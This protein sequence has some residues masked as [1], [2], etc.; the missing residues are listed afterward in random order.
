MKTTLIYII[1]FSI[2][3]LSCLQNRE[4]EST[5][6]YEENSGNNALKIKE[7]DSTIC[8]SSNRD[9][10]LYKR[11]ITKDSLIFKSKLGGRFYHGATKRNI[12]K[13]FKLDT[14]S[15]TV[16][17]KGDHLNIY[18][19]VYEPSIDSKEIFETIKS[20]SKTTDNLN[21]YHDFFKR[22]LIFTHFNS[23]NKITIIAFN[24]FL[25]NKLSDEF[26]DYFKQDKRFFENVFMTL[27]I[28]NTEVLITSD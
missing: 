15:C 28:G 23:K 7:N 19:I 9:I 17:V 4:T 2:T 12:E 11:F 22:G 24:P 14:Y 8:L 25:N 16:S 1:L 27:G 3:N 6:N 26:K 5:V 21:A 13:L 20:M 10:K 18:D